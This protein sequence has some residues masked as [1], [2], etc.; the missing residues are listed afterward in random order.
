MKNDPIKTKIISSISTIE[1]SEATLREL[2][3]TIESYK[4][5]YLGKKEFRPKILAYG[6]HVN[7]YVNLEIGDKQTPD[8]HLLNLPKINNQDED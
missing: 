6:D 7:F 3:A 8:K 1:I 5:N 2:L 4:D